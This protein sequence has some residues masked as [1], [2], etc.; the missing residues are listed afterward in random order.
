M[1]QELAYETQ[2]GSRKPQQVVEVMSITPHFITP[3]PSRLW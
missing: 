3:P 2:E 1:P